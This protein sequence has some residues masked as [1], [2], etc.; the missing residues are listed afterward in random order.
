MCLILLWGVAGW[1][2]AQAVPALTSVAGNFQTVDGKEYKNATVS[3]VEPD[4]IVLTTKFGISK[5]YFVELPNDVQ[6]RF[7]YDAGSAAQFTTVQQAAVAQSNAATAA[8]EQQ[9]AAERQRALQQQQVAAA[10]QRQR[11]MQQEQI[12][13]QQQQRQLKAQQKQ[14]AK[15]A[16][17]KQAREQQQRKQTT[18]GDHYTWE[19][20]THYDPASG[21]YETRQR[22]GNARAGSYHYETHGPYGGNVTDASWGPAPNRNKA[23]KRETPSP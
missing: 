3:R 12:A 4:G 1:L 8:Q 23:K 2:H 18:T 20:N 11:E 10:Q 9:Q 21:V 6:Q 16:A 15:I 13:A 7:H 19:S 5:V 22:S 14:E 17:Q